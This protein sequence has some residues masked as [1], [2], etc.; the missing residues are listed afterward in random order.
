MVLCTVACFVERGR[1]VRSFDESRVVAGSEVGSAQA[2]NIGEGDPK[3]DL[4]VAQ[5][6]GIWCAAG[7]LLAQEVLRDPVPVLGGGAVGVVLGVPVAHEE[8]LHVPSLLL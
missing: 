6:V 8:G 3:L 7:A 5:H 2:A 1:S 4:P